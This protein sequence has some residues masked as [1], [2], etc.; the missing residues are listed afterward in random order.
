MD[1]LKER[2][3]DALADLGGSLLEQGIRSSPDPNQVP[4]PGAW[5][6][7]TSLSARSLGGGQTVRVEV[8]LVIPDPDQP[9]AELLTLADQLDKAL[10]VPYLVPVDDIDL[11]TTLTLPD[12]PSLPAVLLA[13]DL[14]V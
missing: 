8:W 2:L 7:P 3:T 10:S 6:H 13:V 4:V 9:W 1:P 11:D 5:L 14:D 12:N